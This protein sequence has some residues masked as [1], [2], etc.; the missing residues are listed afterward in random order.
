MA[1]SDKTP[2]T[3]PRPPGRMKSPGVARGRKSG[4]V[5]S[6]YVATAAMHVLRGLP[7]DGSESSVRGLASD[8]FLPD[9]YPIA[10]LRSV[11]VAL[12]ARFAHDA[13]AGFASTGTHVFAFLIA[14]SERASH[15]RD[16]KF[17]SCAAHCLIDS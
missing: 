10:A 15:R 16:H 12:R 9:S 6:A 7:T 14:N 8:G 3:A 4:Q 1:L 11:T 5:A 17:E 13:E 2:A